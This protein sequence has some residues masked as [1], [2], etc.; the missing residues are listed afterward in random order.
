M[1][2]D[3]AFF[4]NVKIEPADEV[5]TFF[6]EKGFKK[7]RKSGGKRGHA[8]TDAGHCIRQRVFDWLGAPASDEPGFAQKMVFQMGDKLGESMVEIAQRTGIY[9]NHEG[10]IL[11]HEDGLDHPFSGRYDLEAEDPFYETV[12]GMRL[13]DD[14]GN[15]PFEFK[16]IK[17][18]GFDDVTGV[19]KGGPNVGKPYSFPGAGSRPKKDHVMQLHHYLKD[20][21]APYGYIVYL[22]KNDQRMAFHRVYWSDAVWTEIVDQAIVVEEYVRHGVVPPRQGLH[23]GRIQFYQ[24]ASGDNQPGDINWNEGKYPCM[25]KGK[26]GGEAGCCKFMRLCYRDDIMKFGSDKEKA[27]LTKFESFKYTEKALDV[28][29]DKIRS[30]VAEDEVV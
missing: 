19:Y 13:D 3:D 27:V 26:D 22:N 5:M 14:A 4:E 10:N 9:I 6:M 8:P 25:W 28:D 21:G 24:R 12:V 11:I 17:S 20:L 18:N 16:T 7:R 2:Y 29:L 23:Q 15:V 1:G 30:D